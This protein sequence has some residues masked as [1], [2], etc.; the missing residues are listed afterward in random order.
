MKENVFKC[1]FLSAILLV[2]VPFNAFALEEIRKPVEEDWR[3]FKQ[4]EVEFDNINYGASLALFEK[5]KDIRRQE[6][7]WEKYTLE[8][9]MLKSAVKRADDSLEEILAYLK[10]REYRDALS[11]LDQVFF[12]YGKDSF[13]NSFQKVYE[14]VCKRNVYP[15]ADYYI[16]KIYRL[17]G[18]TDLAIKYFE[19]ALEN[20]NLLDVKEQEYDIYY[21]IA[22]LYELTGNKDKQETYLLKV[23]EKDERFKDKGV[24]VNAL[25]KTVKQ[26]KADSVKKYFDLYRNENIFSI[27][28]C[29]DLAI[30]YDEEGYSDKAL[31]CACF[32]ALTAFT[33]I[34]DVMTEREIE[35]K[36]IDLQSLLA[37]CNKY[38]EIIE[39]GN[40]NGTWE[41]FNLFAKESASQGCI[42]FAT[43][44]YKILSLSQPVEYWR[45]QAEKSILKTHE[46]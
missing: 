22:Y 23:L 37:K 9:I 40:K 30:L 4:A 43:E 45:V 24:F 20:K 34:I 3:I 7:N 39:W 1:I 6:C 8:T 19:A 42:I 32:G 21:D 44:L 33:K 25:I 46:Y 10:E 13:G 2:L 16:G 29:H 26:N 15:E 27:K 18:E 41:M 11:I 38:P 28:A 17:E 14:K 31:E 36:Y 12:L 5:A 35:F